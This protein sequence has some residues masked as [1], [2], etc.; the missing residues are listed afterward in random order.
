MDKNDAQFLG[1]VLKQEPERF[2]ELSK[3]RANDFKDPNYTKKPNTQLWNSIN[4]I[5]KQ[6]LHEYLR[7]IVL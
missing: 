2:E 5:P 4:S 3:K 6:K 7:P 1:Q